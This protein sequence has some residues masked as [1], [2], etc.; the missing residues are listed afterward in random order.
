MFRISLIIFLVFLPL[1]ASAHS[2]LATLSPKDGSVLEQAPTEVKMVFK[3]LVKLIKL[4]MQKLSSD[5][6]S[7]LFGGLFISHK[8]KNIALDTH[9][10]MKKSK[11]YL[12]GLPALDAGD[13][14]I[15]WRALGEDGHVIKGEFRFKV[16]GI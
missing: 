15:K 9:F 7:S 8:D 3:S 5:E 6:R 10:L 16:L 14:F 13:Y 2:P 4:E 12:I 11:Q 1:A